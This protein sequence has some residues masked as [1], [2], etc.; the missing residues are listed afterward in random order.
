[1]TTTAA[2]AVKTDSSTDLAGK[3]SG[4]KI[5]NATPVFRT[6]VMLKNPSMTEIDSL[7]SKRFWISALVQRSSASV[8]AAK[9]MYGNRLWNLNGM[10]FNVPLRIT[11]T[12]RNHPVDST[13]SRSEVSYED[14]INVL[15]GTGQRDARMVFSIR[16]FH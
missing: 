9:T 13:S 3:L 15:G 1:M 6:Y 11:S 12:P 8:A 16:I 2:K 5:P 4:S 7:R 10:L 14:Y